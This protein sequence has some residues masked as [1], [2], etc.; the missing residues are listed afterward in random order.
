M[1]HES[2]QAL[3]FFPIPSAADKYLHKIVCDEMPCGLK[4]YME[5]EL[6]P[7]IHLKVGKGISLSATQC[8]MHKE[9]FWY[10]LYVKGLYYNGHDRPDVVK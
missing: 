3:Q 1:V 7:W 9:G 5:L 8:W 4:H 2:R 6:F 10:I